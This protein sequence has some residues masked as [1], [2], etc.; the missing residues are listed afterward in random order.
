MLPHIQAK[1]GDELLISH[2]LSPQ[3][4]EKTD[5]YK[6]TDVENISIEAK[7]ALEGELSASSGALECPSLPSIDLS[8]PFLCDGSLRN[9]RG[10]V[11]YCHAIPLSHPTVHLIYKRQFTSLR[12]NQAWHV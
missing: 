4:N 3:Y 11:Y 6:T 2:T 5:E 8:I 10:A 9:M 1:D 7:R 12:I